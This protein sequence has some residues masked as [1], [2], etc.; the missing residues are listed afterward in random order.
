M[1]LFRYTYILNGHYDSIQIYIYTEWSLWLYSDIH[2]YWVVTM[3]LFRYTYILS[4]HYDSTQIYIY[5]E[6]SLWLYSDIHIYWVVTYGY[7]CII[8]QFFWR[9]HKEIP[10]HYMC[11]TLCVMCVFVCMVAESIWMFIDL[12][13]F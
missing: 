1:T 2:I 10:V 6:W 13:L 11:I 5:N 8:W 12:F 3:T 4:G 7:R 9:S